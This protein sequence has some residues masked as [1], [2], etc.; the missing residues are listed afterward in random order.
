MRVKLILAAS[1]LAVSLSAGYVYV[2]HLPKLSEGDA[3]VLGDF[4]NTT[5]QTVFDGGLREALEVSLEQSPY[6]VVVSNEKVT[7]AM[8]VLGRPANQAISREL[9]SGICEGTH[10]K[11][12][13]AGG[14]SAEDGKYQI[15]L[16]ALGCDGG[17]SLVRTRAQAANPR[18][19]LPALGKAASEL[20]R[21]FGEKESS[22]EKFDTPLERAT[23]PSLEALKLYS[24]GRRLT[25]DKGA[26]EGVVALQ[27]AVELDPRFA[28]AYSSLAI[29]HYNLN[30]NVQAS[31]EIRRAFEM[32]D[33]QT[34][35]QR[36]QTTTLYYDLGTGDIQKAISSYKQWLRL[37]PRDDVPWGDLSSEYFLIGD[38]EQAAVH[39]REA[40]RLE[41]SSV[42]WFENLSTADIALNRFDDAKAVLREAFARKLEDSSLNGN[43]YALAFL[44][45]DR[46]AMDREV[47]ATSGKASGEDMM[48]AMEADTEAYYG[49]LKKARELS[50]QAVE[51]ARKAELA[52][53]AAIW[54][55]LAALREAAFGNAGEARK[56]AEEVLRLAPAS[57]DAQ[58]L[59]ALVVAWSGDEKQTKTMLDDLRARYVSNTVVQLEWIPVIGARVELGRANPEGA[60]HTLEA[61]AKYERGQMI[62]NLSNC[63]LLPVYVR[64]E[65]YLAAG[66]GPQAMAEF[67]KILDDRGLVVNCWAGSL[68]LLG[69][70]RAQVKAGY[71]TAAHTSYEQFLAQ[72]SQA[73]A[74]IPIYK[75]ARSEFAKLK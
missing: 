40:L 74:E 72:W 25:R 42:A 37:F 2:R 68:A 45:N 33:R 20:R 55:G 11:A 50:R 17:A 62:G 29:N 12:F 64:G 34:A 41:P 48:L 8:R 18:V 53:P 49:H 63:C 59:A 65:A 39:A 32:A 61:A 19:I 46:A 1:L 14:I 10:A 38:Y 4:A 13:V 16:E 35:R 22:I 52:E 70:A 57:R 66:Q 5:G 56:G 9:A 28:L 75:A 36:L 69:K 54:Q 7:E 3:I 51:S 47:K 71:R 31:D 67:Q 24:E 21:E 60:L 27:K 30:Q 15:S 73:D 26:L 43:M 6:L 23:S 58:T 44:R